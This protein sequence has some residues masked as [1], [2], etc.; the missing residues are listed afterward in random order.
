MNQIGLDN[1][2]KKEKN[3]NEIV[4]YYSEEHENLSFTGLVIFKNNLI[5]G[6]GIKSFFQECTNLK[7]KENYYNQDYFKS[8]QSKRNNRLVC[9]THPHNTYIQILSEVGIFGFII[10]LMIF[11]KTLLTNIKIS[12]KKNENR[13]HK[14]YFFINLSLLINLWPLVPS[15]SFFNNWM[16]LVIFFP[17]G[18]WLYVK[19]IIDSK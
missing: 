2:F 7:Q 15:G 8:Q 12:L 5:F 11:I 4:R 16:S 18:F 14:V 19:N 6:T 13:L 10:V 1:I 9:S 3:K 17:L